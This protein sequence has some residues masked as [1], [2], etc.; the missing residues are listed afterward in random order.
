MNLA[1]QQCDGWNTERHK[2][3]LG[4]GRPSVIG[5][6]TRWESGRHDDL[7]RVAK[8]NMGKSG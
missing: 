3:G 1:D 7:G 2:K 8:F 6:L 5:G 4:S